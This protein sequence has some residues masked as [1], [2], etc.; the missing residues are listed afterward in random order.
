MGLD[1]RRNTTDRCAESWSQLHSFAVYFPHKASQ[2][3]PTHSNPYDSFF[4][5]RTEPRSP[6]SSGGDPSHI[7]TGPAAGEDTFS[8]GTFGDELGTFGHGGQGGGGLGETS[9]HVESPF[10]TTT[11]ENEDIFVP[12][13]NGT[14]MGSE[15]RGEDETTGQAWDEEMRKLL[16]GLEERE[17][18]MEREGQRQQE[19]HWTG[20]QAATV[21]EWTCDRMGLE[22]AV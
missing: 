9:R 18:V 11:E 17:A 1:P 10:N 8:L 5:L 20:E 21:T 7:G 3:R 16:E 13:T 14:F 15:I 4:N 12:S 19:V 2:Y 22:V 6:P